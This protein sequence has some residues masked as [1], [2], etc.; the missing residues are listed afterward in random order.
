MGKYKNDRAFP[1]KAQYSTAIHPMHQGNPVIEALPESLPIDEIFDNLTYYP[2]YSEDMRHYE[3]HER[4]EMTHIIKYCFQPWS[5]HT[6][7]AR[8]LRQSLLLGYISRNP[9]EANYRRKLGE[10][11]SCVPK[12]DYLFQS[13]SCT[14]AVSAGFAVIGLSG[15]GKTSS[16]ENCLSGYP[17]IIKHEEY[18]GK[19]FPHLQIVWMKV[20]CPFDGS[21][22]AVCSSFFSAFDELTGDDTYQRFVV[23][24]RGTTA[25]LITQMAAIAFRHSLGVL[26]IDEIQ[27]I[28]AAKSGGVKEMNN[29]IKSLVNQIGVPIILVGTPEAMRYI[30]CD[31]MDAR[32]STGDGMIMMKQLKKSSLEWHMFIS[33]IWR[34]QWTSVPT[35]LT[36]EIEDVFYKY[37]I[38]ILAYAVTLYKVVQDVAIEAGEDG[39]S[40]EI[41]VELIHKVAKS[42]AFSVMRQKIRN[43]QSP[44]KSLRND[45][46]IDMSWE[47]QHKEEST[48]ID[49]STIRKSIDLKREK[50]KKHEVAEGSDSSILSLESIAEQGLI[51]GEDEI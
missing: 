27:N 14:N 16:V 22:K 8:Q 32:R 50:R 46:D 9:L 18:Y 28:S 19:P 31:F 30:S 34:Y 48:R 40:E 43:I 36:K 25:Q 21:V 41:T 5:I 47:E 23:H 49:M 42:D 33:G 13:V 20:N 1:V 26:V 35:I 45:A 11:A 4:L 10:I 38:G 51:L 6:S 7:L 44:P 3:P 37:S 17:Q 39:D 15:M 2:T 24:E 12:K 29:F